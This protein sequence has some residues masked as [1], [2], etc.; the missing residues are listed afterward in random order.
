MKSAFKLEEEVG[1]LLHLVTHINLNPASDLPPSLC[2]FRE[3]HVIFSFVVS[4]VLLSSRRVWDST[5]RRL[6]YAQQGCY[7]SSS[8]NRHSIC[9]EDVTAHPRRPRLARV[10]PRV[11]GGAACQNRVIGASRLWSLRL[12]C[13]SSAFLIPVAGAIYILYPCEKFG[14]DLSFL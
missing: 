2:K 13:C 14:E 8:F 3:G 12:T 9:I 6:K 5:G 10:S 7:Q 1:L 4:L 11:V